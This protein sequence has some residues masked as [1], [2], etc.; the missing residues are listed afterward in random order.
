MKRPLFDGAGAIAAILVLAGAPSAGWAADGA[1]TVASAQ[2]APAVP[3]IEAVDGDSILVDGVE[4]RLMGFDTPEIERSRCEGERR[5]GLL[6]KRRLAELIASKQAMALTFSGQRDRYKRPLGHL[7]VG[8]VN[9]RE[10][11]IAEG[12][13]RPYN[14]GPRKGWCSRDSRDDL[15]PGPKPARETGRKGG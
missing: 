6:A 7:E 5:V 10:T 3:L 11:L 13:A 15:V 9:V 1:P 14:G 4:W 8:G 12:Y 2:A